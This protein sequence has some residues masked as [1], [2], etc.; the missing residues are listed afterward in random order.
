MDLV[1][2][3]DILI[4][5]TCMFG[6]NPICMGVT[7]LFGEHAPSCFGGTGTNVDYCMGCRYYGV[8]VEDIINV[9]AVEFSWHKRKVSNKGDTG[10]DG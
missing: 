3:D 5:A 6:D 8:Q 10:D 4:N 1:D 9:P 7:E 2:R